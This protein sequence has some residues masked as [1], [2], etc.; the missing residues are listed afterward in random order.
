MRNANVQRASQRAAHITTMLCNI[1]LKM[2][3]LVNI[4]DPYDNTMLWELSWLPVGGGEGRLY[5]VYAHER[6]A[7]RAAWRLYRKYTGE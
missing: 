7:V 1:G 3:V 5:N 2:D 4:S 6:S